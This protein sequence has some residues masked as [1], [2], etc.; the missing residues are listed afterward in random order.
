MATDLYV[1]LTYDQYKHL[2]EDLRNFAALET[3]HD[4]EGKEKDLYHASFRFRLG[5]IVVEAHGPLV[6]P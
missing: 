4:G 3:I 5:D 2:E 1:H 6:K